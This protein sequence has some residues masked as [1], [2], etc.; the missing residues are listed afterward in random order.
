MFLFHVRSWKIHFARYRILDRRY[1]HTYICIL[2]LWRRDY[3]IILVSIEKQLRFITLLVICFFLRLFLRF[4]F[5]LSDFISD[6]VLSLPRP[7]PPTPSFS[8]LGVYLLMLLPD[9]FHQSWVVFSFHLLKY[10]FS[11]FR[12]LNL[13]GTS[14]PVLGLT[15]STV[16]FTCLLGFLFFS[17]F[18]DIF[19]W[20]IFRFTKLVFI[21][22]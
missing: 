1:I 19:F 15:D 18:L 10:C 13:S 16:Y 9:V 8:C 11:P 22:V 20:P 17:F 5:C 4:S 2:V 21:S 7:S 14:I 12:M 3:S 6:D